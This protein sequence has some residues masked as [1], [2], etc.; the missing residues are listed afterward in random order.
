VVGALIVKYR[1]GILE[2]RALVNIPIEQ[3]LQHGDQAERQGRA[4]NHE[5]QGGEE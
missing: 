3:I 4:K 5:Q 2:S 1:S